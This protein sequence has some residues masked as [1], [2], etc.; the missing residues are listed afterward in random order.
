MQTILKEEC[1]LSVDQVSKAGEGKGGNSN[2]GNT[3]RRF[4]TTKLADTVIGCVKDEYKQTIKQLHQDLSVIL[5]IICS[6][7]KVNCDKFEGLTER[8]S[9]LIAEKLP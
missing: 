2:T 4:F 7:Q 6:A 3:A 8:V 5:R 9:L 1:G